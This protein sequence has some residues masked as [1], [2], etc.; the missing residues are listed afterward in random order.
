MSGT[1]NET[2]SSPNEVAIPNRIS[3]VEEATEN[4]LMRIEMNH[5]KRSVCRRV[6]VTPQILIR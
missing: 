3:P 2:A 4:P 5:T 1:P 6:I